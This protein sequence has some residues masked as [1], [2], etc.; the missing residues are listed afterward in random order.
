MLASP[1][2]ELLYTTSFDLILSRVFQARKG[3]KHVASGKRPYWNAEIASQFHK[4]WH[5]R[6]VRNAFL[7]VENDLSGGELWK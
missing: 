3:R 4:G 7:F 1:F 2:R 6:S 5:Y